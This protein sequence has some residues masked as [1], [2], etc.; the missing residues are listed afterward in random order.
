VGE[1]FSQCVVFH[2][3]VSDFFLVCHGLRVSERSRVNSI[4][5]IS[6]VAIA[7]FFPA[8]SPVQKKAT[9]YEMSRLPLQWADEPDL[10]AINPHDE[11][12]ETQRPHRGALCARPERDGMV[13]LA[14]RKEVNGCF[15]RSD[16]QRWSW[17]S[18]V[19]ARHCLLA[20]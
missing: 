9:W 7:A 19:P 4:V 1:G 6:Y 5:A 20:L 13:T 12:Q 14:R 3:K 11:V 18:Y 17:K 15:T 10:C 8:L 2:S 16:R